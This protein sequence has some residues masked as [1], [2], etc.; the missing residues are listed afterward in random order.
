MKKLIAVLLILALAA[1]FT[2]CTKNNADGTE[3]QTQAATQAQ[4][5][6]AGESTEAPDDAPKGYYTFTEKNGVFQVYVPELWR[7]TGLIIEYDE[8]STRYNRF[9][10]KEAF[11]QG[12]GHVFTIAV[13]SDPASF[14]DCSAMPHCEE[15]YRSADRQVYS[16]YPTDVQF[17]VFMEP[18]SDDFKKQF[19]EYSA[20]SETMEGIIASIKWL[21]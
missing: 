18:S 4:T 6:A 11:E 20:L 2:A 5:E 19:E 13:C 16:V 1:V 15:L 9:V 7:K 14:I 8:G 21:D 3:A 12:A 10:Y 17:G